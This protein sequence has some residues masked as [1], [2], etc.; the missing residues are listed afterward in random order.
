MDVNR[1]QLEL[2]YDI[3]SSVA[4]GAQVCLDGNSQLQNEEATGRDKNRTHAGL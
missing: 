3:L 4:G 2:R 1:S